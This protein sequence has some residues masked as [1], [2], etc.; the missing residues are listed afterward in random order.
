M[1]KSTVY[2][3]KIDLGIPNFN[4]CQYCSYLGLLVWYVDKSA[5]T[6]EVLTVNY[7]RGLNVDKMET[8]IFSAQKMWLNS[9]AYITTAHCQDMQGNVQLSPIQEG[10]TTQNQTHKNTNT[11]PSI[12]SNERLL[13]G[14]FDMLSPNLVSV[15]LALILHGALV[16]FCPNT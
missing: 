10:K 2:A 12:W 5:E 11:N 7:I 16:T 9:G 15:Q 1:E 14:I 3:K 4:L 6:C 13:Q 8:G